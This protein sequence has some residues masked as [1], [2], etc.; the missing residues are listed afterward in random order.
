MKEGYYKLNCTQEEILNLINKEAIKVNTFFTNGRANTS[1]N[2]E[3]FKESVVCNIYEI[4]HD[5]VFCLIASHRYNLPYAV[6]TT[7][8][9][10]QAL[11]PEF[12]KD[13]DGGWRGAG[14]LIDMFDEYKHKIE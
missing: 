12:I 9:K 14:T 8:S 1:D 11:N 2:D 4:L 6:H 10:L 7:V 3:R 5:N 13:T